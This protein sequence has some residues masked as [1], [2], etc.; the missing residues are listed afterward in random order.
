MSKPGVVFKDM[1]TCFY[2]AIAIQ[3]LDVL[4]KEKALFVLPNESMIKN[5]SSCPGI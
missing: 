5:G 3:T 4:C 1:L 2:L